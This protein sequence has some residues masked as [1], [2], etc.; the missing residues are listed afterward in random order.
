MLIRAEGGDTHETATARFRHGLEGAARI[1]RRVSRAAV[2]APFVRIA[3]L[4]ASNP[5]CFAMR[6]SIRG[7]TYDDRRRSPLTV[8]SP[9]ES[10]SA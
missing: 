4:A 1:C 3:S 9:A 7:L 6:E 5:F 2:V 8:T 10:Y